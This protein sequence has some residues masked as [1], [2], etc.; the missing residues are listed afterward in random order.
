[1]LLKSVHGKE[2][3][4]SDVK[5][6]MMLLHSEF[7]HMKLEEEDFIRTTKFK[8]PDPKGKARCE[9]KI[10]EYENE[11][12]KDPLAKMLDMVRAGVTF[13]VHPKLTK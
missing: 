6:N 2:M 1:M 5:L 11:G 7:V 8:T 10:E 9:V 4:V 13:T 3:Q 12:A